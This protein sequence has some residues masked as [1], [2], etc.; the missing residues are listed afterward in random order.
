MA[1]QYA[2]TLGK[3]AN[4]QTLVSATLARGEVRVVASLRLFLP[5]NWTSDPDR[6]ARARVPD[7]QQV[8]RSKTVIAIEEVDRLCGSAPCSPM[9]DMD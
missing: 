3:N 4:C 2:S 7:E 6:M 1:P 5:E 9:P 8:F